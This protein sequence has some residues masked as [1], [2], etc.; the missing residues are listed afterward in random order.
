MLEM[1]SLNA[2]TVEGSSGTHS[3]YLLSEE[4][5]LTSKLRVVLWQVL[6]MGRHKIKA[7]QPVHLTAYLKIH[8]V[9]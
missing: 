7:Q 5:C 6:L 8:A 1:C 2:V 9:G 4:T 3:Q